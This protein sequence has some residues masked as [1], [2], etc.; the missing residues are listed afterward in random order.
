LRTTFRQIQIN[1]HLITQRRIANNLITWY[2][3]HTTHRSP[4][5]R[6]LLFRFDASTDFA[7][8]LR[9]DWPSRLFMARRLL[10]PKGNSE[11]VDATGMS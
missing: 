4:N 7:L 5:C 11:A 2:R 3:P 9:R 1:F 6:S 8:R 10:V